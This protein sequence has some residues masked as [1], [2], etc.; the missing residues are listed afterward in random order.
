MQEI[1]QIIL[2]FLVPPSSNTGRA[3]NSVDVETDD[4]KEPYGIAR[5]V[6]L[7]DTIL[8]HH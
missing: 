4:D 8:F 6:D 3:S 7:D 1:F 5:A 2:V